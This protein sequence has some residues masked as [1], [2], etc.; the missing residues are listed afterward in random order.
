M[1]HQ[2]GDTSKKCDHVNNASSS[3]K[4]AH[5]ESPDYFWYDH[6]K[7]QGISLNLNIF[8][9]LAFYKLLMKIIFNLHF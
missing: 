2:K 6:I 8:N 9:T 5:R 7:Y 4:Q 3:G 1:T